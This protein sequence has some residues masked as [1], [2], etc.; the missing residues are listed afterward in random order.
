MS[1]LLRFTVSVRLCATVTFL[2]YL[3]AGA[4][5][6]LP[7]LVSCVRC[8]K[9]PHHTG[10]KTGTACPLS[11]RGQGHDCHSSNGKSSGSIKLCPD[12]CLRHDE[13]NN[14]VASIA[15]FLSPAES[16]IP[17]MLPIGDLSPEQPLIFPTRT[18]G[19][20]DRPPSLL[21]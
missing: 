4:S 21:S 12:G 6:S 14:E 10:M 2:C 20:P 1:T 9:Q 19:P 8:A 15:K 3:A 13:Q 11:Y 16:L 18:I 5:L 17:G 7:S